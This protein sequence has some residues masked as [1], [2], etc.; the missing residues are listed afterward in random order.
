MVSWTLKLSK[1]DISFFTKSNI[2]SQ[3]LEDLFVEFTWPIGKE[4][5]HVWVLSVD[6]ASHLK[7]SGVGV[8]LEEP[9]GVLI[10]KSLRFEL[11]VSNN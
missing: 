1:Y 9:G 3:V 10:E 6:G 2:K 11:K 8:M 4:N 5:S 7:G